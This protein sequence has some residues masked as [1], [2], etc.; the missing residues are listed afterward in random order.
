MDVEKKVHYSGRN[1]EESRKDSDA[2][3]KVN[4]VEVTVREYFID[5]EKYN[6]APLDPAYVKEVED[7]YAKSLETK[8]RLQVDPNLVKSII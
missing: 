8:Q 3:I 1:T 4:G 7:H 2:I 6:K 5:P